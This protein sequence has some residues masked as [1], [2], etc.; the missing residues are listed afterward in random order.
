MDEKE[1]LKEQDLNSDEDKGFLSRSEI[2]HGEHPLSL[3]ETSV[4]NKYFQVCFHP[5]LLICRYQHHSNNNKSIK[6]AL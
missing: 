6:A 3:G 2:P 1:G 4:W 5:L